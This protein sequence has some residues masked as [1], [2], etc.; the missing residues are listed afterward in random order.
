MHET[1]GMCGKSE[2]RPERYRKAGGHA[3]SGCGSGV[4]E[5][6]RSQSGHSCPKLQQRHVG[7]SNRRST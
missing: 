2:M 4:L 3:Q 5:L 1:R 7:T 6:S